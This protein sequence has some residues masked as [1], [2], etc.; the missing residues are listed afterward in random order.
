M[1]GDIVPAMPKRTPL[2]LDDIIGG[3]E[4][5]EILGID[6]PTLS[7]WVAGGRIAYLKKVGPIYLYDRREVARVARVGPAP[8]QRF[9]ITA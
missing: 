7:R 8:A 1:R 3:P 9:D 6:Q 5:A 2:H 4:A